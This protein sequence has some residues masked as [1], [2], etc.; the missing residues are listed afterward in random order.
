MEKEN[1][2]FSISYL[3]HANLNNALEEPFKYN[4]SKFHSF[5]DKMVISTADKDK[6][7][8]KHEITHHIDGVY[9]SKELR[10]EL[11]AIYK[12]IEGV[13]VYSPLSNS[14]LHYHVKTKA[15]ITDEETIL[16]GDS[17]AR[18]SV[19]LNSLSYTIRYLIKDKEYHTPYVT[20]NK[21]HYFQQDPKSHI[22]NEAL[23]P[24]E[25]DFDIFWCPHEEKS[26]QRTFQ[27]SNR[28]KARSIV[29]QQL[30][31]PI[32]IDKNLFIRAARG[33]YL[34]INQVQIIPLTDTKP[35][36]NAIKI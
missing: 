8:S 27:I 32:K 24:D 19:S 5:K 15:A 17:V 11:G 9:S 3:N 26:K 28:P 29:W 10:P 13:L 12:L 31:E 23:K 33:H 22:I 30:N 35:Q 36:A 4:Q 14:S 1:F 6:E 7:E 2:E 18:V 16:I 25:A 21:I 34:L 20:D